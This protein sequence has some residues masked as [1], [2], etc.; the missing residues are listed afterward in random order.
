LQ[1]GENIN[2]KSPYDNCRGLIQKNKF[3]IMKKLFLFALLCGSLSN[4]AQTTLTYTSSG[5]TVGGNLGIN[6][7][8][9]ASILDVRASS[10]N[11]AEIRV[12]GSG[13]F[14]TDNSIT[15][16]RTASFSEYMRIGSAA[17][18]G[19][20]GGANNSYFVDVLGG[21]TGTARPIY[22]RFSQDNGTTYSTA[23]TVSSAGV[24]ISTT[25]PAYNLDVAGTAQAT[26]FRVSAIQT[27]PATATSTGITG[28][29]RFTSTGIF[30]C[31]ATN[32]WIRCT[33][34]TF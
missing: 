21:S 9:P 5:F 12:G 33:G 20:F 15:I 22:Y 18:G 13:S 7:T 27:A 25:A 19:L 26:I 17:A 30:I 29:I 10:G 24:G 32:I 8:S 3:K 31:T 2:P 34:A 1:N 14:N 16:G 6:T 23:L 11:K 28:E 4:F